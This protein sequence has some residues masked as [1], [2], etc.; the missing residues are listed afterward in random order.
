NQFWRAGTLRLYD[1]ERGTYRHAL[2]DGVYWHMQF[3]TCWCA[4]R[5]PDDVVGRVEAAYRGA[6]VAGCPAAAEEAVFAQAVVQA[7]AYWVCVTLVRGLGFALAKDER[8]G[9]ATMRPRL[10]TRLDTFARLAETRGHL[11]HTAQLA[12]QVSA[13]LRRRWPA[14]QCEL[15]MYAAFQ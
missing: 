6:L 12:R 5:T 9:L 2:I 10:V 4:G 1:Y 7:A 3:P 14:R 13:E 15:A 8:W 11:A